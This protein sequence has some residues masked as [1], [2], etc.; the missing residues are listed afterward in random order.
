M[1]LNSYLDTYKD[2]ILGGVRCSERGKPFAQGTIYGLTRTISIIK[3]YQNETGKVINWDDIDIDFYHNFINY[4]RCHNLKTN[5]I[6]KYVCI[7]K[8]I[9]ANAEYEGY[10]HNIAYRSK[11]FKV[12][13]ESTEGIFLTHEELNAM[14]SVDLSAYPRVYST[15]RDIFLIGVYTVQRFSDY[16]TINKDCLSFIRDDYPILTIVQ[17]KTGKKVCIPCMKKLYKILEKYNFTLPHICPQNFNKYIKVIAKEA[18][19]GKRADFVTSHTARRTGATLLYLAGVDLMDIMKITGHSSSNMLKLYIK[20]DELDVAEKLIN[21]YP[22]FKYR[23][24]RN[25]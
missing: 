16:S 6:G 20:A 18:G 11:K 4:L 21:K 1:T 7:L 15:V 22:F 3:E 8:T 12:F 25:N 13:K 9:L 2:E 24:E 10:H 14:Y 5:T 17:K 19:L 23:R